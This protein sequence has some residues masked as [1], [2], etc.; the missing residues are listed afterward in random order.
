MK[1]REPMS[2]Q[3]VKLLTE[4]RCLCAH[5]TRYYITSHVSTSGVDLFVSQIT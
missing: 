2:Q 5:M 3:S 1:V 4:E